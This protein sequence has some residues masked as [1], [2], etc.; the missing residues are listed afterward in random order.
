M[1][2]DVDA[3][4]ARRLL[5][6]ADG[7][8][9]LAVYRVFEGDVEK[10]GD[11]EEYD[12]GHH[13]LADPGEGFGREGDG[14]AF[15]VPL[16][17]TAC[18][19]H[20]AERGDERRNLGVGNQRAVDQPGHDPAAEPDKKRHDDR[21]VR[22]RRIDGAGI[23]RDLGEAHGDHRRRADHGA[24][25]QVDA[26]GDDDLG[27]ADGDDADDRHLQDHDRQALGVEDEA[28]V[29]DVPAQDL[30][31]D[32][33]ADEADERIEFVRATTSS[34]LS[35]D[36]SDARRRRLLLCH[37]VH[38]KEMAIACVIMRRTG[39]FARKFGQRW[40]SSAA[41]RTRCQF[42]FWKSAM[43]AGVTSWKGM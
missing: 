33:D 28:L 5:V 1:A 22:E 25:R 37:G 11:G 21:K 27:D 14:L 31:D 9:V 2:L 32:H 43:F 38:R 23:G 35:C 13:A 42:F 18:R 17:D 20:H 8:G 15:R 16:G 36:G 7:I 30:E 24:R 3:R 6:G 10:S 26:A 39:R 34:A 19:H 41:A 40:R 4:H 12:D 29:L